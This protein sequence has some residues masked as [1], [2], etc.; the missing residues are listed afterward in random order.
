MPQAFL[1]HKPLPFSPIMHHSPCLPNIQ[2]FFLFQAVIQCVNPPLHGWP[3]KRLYTHFHIYTLS[4]PIILH[5]LNM[6]HHPYHLSFPILSIWPN[7]RRTLSSILLSTSVAS[8]NTLIR[9]F[10]TLSILLV[11]NRSLRLSICTILILDL[12]FYLYIIVFLPFKRTDISTAS[13]TSLTHS[14]CRLLALSKDLIVLATFLLLATYL[15]MTF[16]TISTW[17]IQYIPKIFELW[18]MLK[19]HPITRSSHPNISCYFPCRFLIFSLGKTHKLK[20]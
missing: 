16:S 15:S 4:N 6:A 12:S 19:S 17:L 14:N 9:V 13:C 18:Y 8:H 10:C 20:Y 2:D 3:T 11:S 7:H 5:S 1:P